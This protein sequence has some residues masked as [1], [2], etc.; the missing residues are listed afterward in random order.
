MDNPCTM[1][2]ELLLKKMEKLKNLRMLVQQCFLKAEL[3]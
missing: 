2:Q 1:W 3:N